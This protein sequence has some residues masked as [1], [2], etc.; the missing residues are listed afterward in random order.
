VIVT[1]EQC[2]TQFHLDDSKVPERG[3]RVRCS[4]CK[5]AFFV[6]A[7]TDAGDGVERVVEQA[8]DDAPDLDVGS[9]A[10]DL[11]DS[12][13]PAG[14]DLLG[15]PD[16]EEGTEES[17][18]Q[19]NHEPGADAADSRDVFASQPSDF[20][21]GPVDDFLEG[22][23]AEPD[24]VGAEPDSVG[25]GLDDLAVPGETVAGS[26]FDAVLGDA[27]APAEHDAPD[28][29]DAAP[30][31]VGLG[32]LP[33]EAPLAEA[34]GGLP[35]LGETLPE[36]LEPETVEVD[37]PAEPQPEAAP[38]EE[39]TP[40]EAGLGSPEEWDFFD[41][42]GVSKPEPAGMRIAIGRL[43]VI[44]AQRPPV[45]VERE[46]SRAAIWLERAVNTVGWSVVTLLALAGLHGGLGIAP[47]QATA[48]G[49]PAVQR[50]AEG[51]AEGLELNGVTQR[52][53]ENES[54]GALL[55]VSGELRSVSSQPL[56][57]GSRLELRLL[58]AQGQP[59]SA[60][61]A[62]LGGGL[63]SS[64][65][66]TRAPGELREQLAADAEARA[67]LPLAPGAVLPVQAV[68]ARVPGL[69][70]RFDW[71]A[72]PVEAPPAPP[73]AQLPEEAEAQDQPPAS[74]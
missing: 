8:L 25:E 57:S 14:G 53:V 52:W 15:K 61:T 31:G 50:P 22:S 5:H 33:G 16:L 54:A 65:L 11:G 3:V 12:L 67:W 34:S 40:P 43:G 48:P 7:Q 60:E 4:R 24:S 21:H 58:D 49:A 69:A 39:P 23:G 10:G 29:L 6:K 51:L 26:D 64:E 30:T 70:A 18:W 55:V 37:P 59:L 44:G 1:C 13:G 62:P 36:P 73:P 47:S 35:P 68:V 45:E 32:A 20:A 42:G 71:V 28:A 72:I 27:G 2:S 56:M 63:A 17:D 38:A 46:T 66:R 41:G 74:S 9:S 19:F